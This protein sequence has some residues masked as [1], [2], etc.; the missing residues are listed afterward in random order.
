MVFR[1]AGWAIFGVTC[2]ACLA[3]EVHT[4]RRGTTP[5]GSVFP[6][7]LVLAITVGLGIVAT[8]TRSNL[9][10]LFFVSWALGPWVRIYKRVQERRESAS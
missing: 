5:T 3:A 9:V 1:V 10:T 8:A 2:V 6:F 7:L 4:R